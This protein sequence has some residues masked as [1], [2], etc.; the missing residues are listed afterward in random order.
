MYVD[1]SWSI[2]VGEV[3][4]PA[5]HMLRTCCVCVVYIACKYSVHSYGK[6]YNHE[7]PN[8]GTKCAVYPSL[9]NNPPFVFWKVL[10]IRWDAVR[11]V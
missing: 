2:I 5:V 7:A 3:P 8:P 4:V 1:I 11:V 9:S 6:P 10:G